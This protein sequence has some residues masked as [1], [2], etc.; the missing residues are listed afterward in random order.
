MPKRAPAA[1]LFTAGAGDKIFIYFY[2]CQITQP[3]SFS[4]HCLIATTAHKLYSANDHTAVDRLRTIATSA[5]CLI[6]QAHCLLLIIRLIISPVSPAA[7]FFQARAPGGLWWL[8]AELYGKWTT[9][10][11]RVTIPELWWGSALTIIFSA[12]FDS[13][14]GIY[15]ILQGLSCG[16][17]H[18]IHRH[19]AHHCFIVP[20]LYGSFSV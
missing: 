7:I 16:H 10:A 20:S 18:F 9:A 12:L 11:P 13:S 5:C 2:F 19:S 4:W 1:T 3:I 15:H 14:I 6:L 17:F 8:W